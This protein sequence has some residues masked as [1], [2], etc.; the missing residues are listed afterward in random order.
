MPSSCEN[1]LLVAGSRGETTRFLKENKTF[2]QELS[3]G[4]I[5]PLPGHLRNAARLAWSS[6]N[7]G[8]RRDVDIRCSSEVRPGGLVY[9]FCT[10]TTAPL[11]WL[12]AV[13]KKYPHLLFALKFQV[14]SAFFTCLVICKNGKQVW[15]QPISLDAFNKNIVELLYCYREPSPYVSLPLDSLDKI[16]F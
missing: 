11:P 6:L 2:A 1:I 12:R 13:A 14:S 10:E 3:F 9:E 7:W 16:S 5:L 4:A 15:K 8:V